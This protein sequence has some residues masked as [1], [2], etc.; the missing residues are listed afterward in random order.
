MIDLE[1]AKQEFKKYTLD[2]D[3]TIAKVNNKIDHSFRVMEISKQIAQEQNLTEDGIELAELIG[4]LHDIA[5][6]EQYK[7]YKTFRDVDSIDHGDYGEKILKQNQYIRKY[8]EIADYDNIILKAIRNHNKFEIEQGLSQEEELF[9]KIIR[10]ADKIDIYYEAAEMFWKDAK[11]I[12]ENSKLS[13]EIEEQFNNRNTIKREKGVQLNELDKMV[14]TL[15]FIYDINFMESFHIIK[16]KDYINR[17]INQFNFSN[18]E[19]KQ[20]IENIRK[21]ANQFLEINQ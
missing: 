21:I 10:D 4:L 14:L 7:Q 13:P 19:T 6:F 11:K 9:A 16:D 20:K 1:K 17:I 8:I 15:S 5:R 2:Y 3:L 12:V 18:E